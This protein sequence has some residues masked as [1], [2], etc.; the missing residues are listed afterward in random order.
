MEIV[1]LNKN[2]DNS[3]SINKINMEYSRVGIKISG[4]L[5]REF[6]RYLEQELDKSN[7]EGLNIEV[8]PTSFII[9]N[10]RIYNKSLKEYISIEEILNDVAI[11]FATANELKIQ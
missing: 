5:H 6:Y 2:N 11:S 8:L 3:L 7:F 1:L 4:I 9:N 10:Q